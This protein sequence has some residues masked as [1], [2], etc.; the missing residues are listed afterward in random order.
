ME[1]KMTKE[2]ISRF[3]T[4]PGK[5]TY[6]EISEVNEILETLHKYFKM[7]SQVNPSV[8]ISENEILSMLAQA[9]WYMNYKTPIKRINNRIL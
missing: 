3:S 4:E 6:E 2:L 8:G 5:M 7:V 9:E 1:N